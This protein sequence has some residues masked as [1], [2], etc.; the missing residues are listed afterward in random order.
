MVGS[1]TKYASYRDIQR[2]LRKLSTGMDVEEKNRIHNFIYE[3]LRKEIKGK[4]HVLT[5]EVSNNFL[6]LCFYFLNYY[7]SS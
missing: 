3:N 7:N 1:K 2:S 4:K 5:P 6:S